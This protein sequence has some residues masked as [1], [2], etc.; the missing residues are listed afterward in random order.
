VHY[1]PEIMQQPMMETVM[2]TYQQREETLSRALARGTSDGA[3][4]RAAHVVASADTSAL[5][6]SWKPRQKAAR[7]YQRTRDP[8]ALA[9]T[10]KK[11]AICRAMLKRMSTYVADQQRLN[12]PAKSS[13][14]IGV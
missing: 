2:P 7:Q 14:K 13:L 10:A 5:R 9:K 8:F 12:K 6:R 4:I 11:R 1:Q 3:A